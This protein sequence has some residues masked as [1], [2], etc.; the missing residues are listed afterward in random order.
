MMLNYIWFSS[1][2]EAWIME[3]LFIAITPRSTMTQISNV[4]LPFLIIRLTLNW[5]YSYTSFIV[6]SLV[7]YL[8]PCLYSI[9]D[10]HLCCCFCHLMSHICIFSCGLYR[11]W[12]QIVSVLLSEDNRKANNLFMCTF[13]FYDNYFTRVTL[14]EKWEHRWNTIVSFERSSLTVQTI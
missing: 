6:S 14:K 3:N 1:F 11:C 2:G 12:Y 7:L 5:T 9:V 8:S 4:L 13:Y 10:C